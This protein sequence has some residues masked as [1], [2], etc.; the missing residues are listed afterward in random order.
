MKTNIILCLL[1]AAV[2][3]AGAAAANTTDALL[4]DLVH[5]DGAARSLARKL[6][7][8]QPMDFAPKLARLLAHEDQMVW[9]AALHVMADCCSQVSVPGRE[10]DRVLVTSAIM[11]L[12]A[13][14]Q[15]YDVKVRALRLLPLVIPEGTDVSPMAALLADEDPHLREWARQ[16]LRDAG[17]TECRW[18]L[19]NALGDAEGEW[20]VAL[21]EALG[22]L[23]HVEPLPMLVDRLADPS[24]EVR[25]AAVRSIAWLGNPHVL[26]RV[27][28]VRK[29][30]RGDM[31][32]AEAF[33]AELL[34]IDAMA[35]NGGLWHTVMDAYM[36]I[37]K[38]AHSVNIKGAALN[39]LGRF[40]NEEAVPVIFDAV[41]GRRGR[42]LEPA[43]LRALASLDSAAAHQAMLEAY[44]SARGDMRHGLLTVFGEKGDPR[45]QDVLLEAAEG[46][47]P[48]LRA[49][50]ARAL[51]ASRMPA[52]GRGVA[53]VAEKATDE[54]RA[55][56]LVGL[57]RLAADFSARNDAPAAGAAW[58]GL[59]RMTDDEAVRQRALEGVLRYPVEDAFDIIISA[60]DGEALTQMPVAA[61][62]GVAGALAGAG[63]DAE[64]EK[65]LDTLLARISE[66]ESV[67]G[68]MQAV[69]TAFPGANFTARMGFLTRW[70]IV[71]PFPWA[72]AEGFSANPVGA[73]DVDVTAA[74]TVNSG[75]LRWT[76]ALLDG[77]NVIVPLNDLIGFHSNCSGYAWCTVSVPEDTP[78]SLRC[79][80]DDGI[81]AWVNGEAVHE[82]NV[83]R[84]TALD[85]D[86][87]DIQL[88]AG[89]NQVLLQITQGGG[90]WNFAARLTR[91]DGS[92]LAFTVNAP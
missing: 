65:V 47:D 58:L 72:Q 66:S 27:R 34:L 30:A 21:I 71:G 45:F 86:V 35:R 57:E 80:S 14:E 81:K 52:A 73:P 91:P 42:E 29:Q 2:L 82:N 40:G 69:H 61:L 3:L 13:P 70:K 43:A 56:L 5:G 75:E 44:P 63:R 90:G 32:T 92:P 51:M 67:A 4:N 64:A 12:L 78:A 38:D 20:A 46:D 19:A 85:S 18:A 49:T 33:D 79:G 25:V 68:V 88:K 39:G 28:Q 24:H 87:V 6:L 7:P 48:A 54:E 89:E 84:G 11:P 53:A 83:D 26:G 50:A 8:R 60:V 23:R 59:Y 41:K 15:P 9:K 37:L 74:Y 76:D 17:T 16:A 62:P 22:S 1:L 55:A 36:T 10:A 31:Q 77:G